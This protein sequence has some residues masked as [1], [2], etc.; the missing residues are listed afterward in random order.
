MR[1]GRC[2]V[3]PGRTPNLDGEEAM[4]SQE[5]ARI[6]NG[7]DSSDSSPISREFFDDFFSTRYVHVLIAS[8][9][10]ENEGAV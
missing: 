9:R 1:A 10:L 8:K 5:L 4:G 6:S 7:E 3:D 2:V